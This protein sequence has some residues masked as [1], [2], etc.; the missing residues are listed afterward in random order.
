MVLGEPWELRPVVNPEQFSKQ[1]LFKFFDLER[2]KTCG[3]GFLSFQIYLFNL[4]DWIKRLKMKKYQGICCLALAILLLI[5][6]SCTQKK[7]PDGLP[8]LYSLTI[9]LTYDDGAPVQG[10]DIRLNNTDKSLTQRWATGGKTDTQGNAVMRTHGEYPGAPTGNFKVIVNKEEI[11]YNNS[12]PPQITGRFNHIEKKYT[13]NQ[14]T[15]LILE[16]KPDTKS[17]EFKVGK[18]VR[19]AIAGPPG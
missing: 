17:A 9:K 15:D 19:E 5:T 12:D 11:V 18:P 1:S 16:V 2:K 14:N 10:A 7:K 13:T 3:M 4:N 8:D 6:V